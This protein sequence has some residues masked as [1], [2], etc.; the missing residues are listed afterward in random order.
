[1]RDLDIIKISLQGLSDERYQEICNPP[2]NFSF[3]R[4]KNQI[5][6][7]YQHRGSC[8]VYIKIIDVALRKDEEKIFY[9][10]FAPMADYLFISYSLIY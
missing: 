3:D 5:E 8:R 10:L 1:M 6:Y 9:K 7:F 2:S 4:F